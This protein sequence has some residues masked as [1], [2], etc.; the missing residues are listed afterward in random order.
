M[1]IIKNRY[2][3][4]DDLM[5][6]TLGDQVNHPCKVWAL[7]LM[8]HPHQLHEKNLLVIVVNFL[9]VVY[10]NNGVQSS[11]LNK[12]IDV[13]TESGLHPNFWL[14]PKQR[15]SQNQTTKNLLVCRRIPF[16]LRYITHHWSC[17]WRCYYYRG[18]HVW[19]EWP[20]E[21]PQRDRH[22]SLGF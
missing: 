21:S 7:C 9:Y 11:L 18:L 20:W 2:L 1:K 16:A 4:S 10:S 12:V 13:H 22:V 5:K 8:T 14:Q 3:Y 15:E 17:K 19:G 6:R